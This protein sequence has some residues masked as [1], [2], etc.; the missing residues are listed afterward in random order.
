MNIWNLI[1]FFQ[2]LNIV[3]LNK[4]VIIGRFSFHPHLFLMSC[5]HLAK[6]KK[7]KKKRDLFLVYMKINIVNDSLFFN[8]F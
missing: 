7:T 8:F 6:E 4:I 2:N 5:N 1:Y 3:L